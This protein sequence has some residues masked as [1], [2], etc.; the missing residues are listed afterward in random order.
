L[1]LSI[2]ECSLARTANRGRESR[3][4]RLQV[5]G[6]ASGRRRVLN[7]YVQG[8]VRTGRKS[9]SGGLDEATGARSAGHPGRGRRV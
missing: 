5:L 6:H 1:G 3:G 8:P 2:A 7:L 9:D 4:G